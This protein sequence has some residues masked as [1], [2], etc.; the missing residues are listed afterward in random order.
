MVVG[1]ACVQG[2]GNRVEERAAPSGLD[3]NKKKG[4]GTKR[5]KGNAC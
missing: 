5:V 1:L 4:G 3:K 2:S